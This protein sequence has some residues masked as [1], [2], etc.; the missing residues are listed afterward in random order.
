MNE[1]L[2]KKAQES[3]VL[4]ARNNKWTIDDDTFDLFGDDD[5]YP[6][7][8]RMARKQYRKTM[9]QLKNPGKIPVE[10]PVTQNSQPIDDGQI[11]R[12]QEA[13]TMT[14]FIHARCR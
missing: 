2:L 6:P 10:K 9:E 5:P 8:I 7:E 11:K 12:A 4:M 13:L 1:R 14:I 3:M